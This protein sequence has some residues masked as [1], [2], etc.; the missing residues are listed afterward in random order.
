MKIWCINLSV[1]HPLHLT[2]YLIKAN[3]MVLSLSSVPN[4]VPDT[5]KVLN[6]YFNGIIENCEYSDQHPVPEW[7]DKRVIGSYLD[8]KLHEKE[9]W[10]SALFISRIPIM[11]KMHNKLSLNT[12]WLELTL[13]LSQLLGIL[14]WIRVCMWT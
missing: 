4:T 11:V 5:Q 13:P 10:I 1:T 8:C 7:M 2:V 3:A 14:L 9:N 6:K 12:S